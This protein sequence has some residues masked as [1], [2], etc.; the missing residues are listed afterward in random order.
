MLF[1]RELKHVCA[2]AVYVV[3]LGFLL[4]GWKTNF[5]GVT[6][7]EISAAAGEEL[8]AD[9]LA[10]GGAFLKKPEK[11]D[12]SY[13][14]RK[15]VVPEKIMCGGTDMLLLEYLKNSYA[16]YPF[17]YYKEV[18]LDDK[19]QEQVLEII[20]EI[21]GLEEEQLS[22]LPDGYFPQVNGNII[23]MGQDGAAFDGALKEDGSLSFSA[24]GHLQGQAGYR[25][26]SDE[27]LSFSAGGQEAVQF[28]AQVSY[29]RFLELMTKVE[30]LIGPGSN[31]SEEM[32]TEYYGQVE[33]TYEEALAAY[34]ETIREDQVSRA[35][36]R[37]F[38]DYM[39][40]M[41]GL[42]PAFVAVVFW[43]KDRRCHMQ[44]LVGSRQT[45]T[46]RLVITRYLALTTAA[47]APAML[48]SFESL[49]PL[50]RY[51]AETGIAIDVFAFAKY[52]LWWLAPTAMAVMALAMFLTILTRLS[53]AIPVALVWWLADSAASGLSGNIGVF[54]LMIRHNLLGGRQIIE[55][56]FTV[57]CLNRGLL[58]LV[59]CALVGLSVMAYERKRDG[60][61]NSDAKPAEI[62][63]KIY[64]WSQKRLGIH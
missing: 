39:G 55:E 9:S 33:M 64:S 34:E 42:Y 11:S 51:S 29:E 6:Q 3:F 47:L 10:A 46:A 45:A 20:K 50:M 56:N 54:T 61:T 32:L 38:C 62:K 58:I 19:E 12:E 28:E 15:K 63:R 2:S 25:S 1:A 53:L 41:L 13:G 49:L 40:R 24:G 36:A 59:S 4:F 14:A 60:R 22:N 48:L 26:C 57:I 16:S 17:G 43:R 44:E 31:Y 35:F 7:R 5:C 21:T 37:L 23:H 8:T 18:V 30:R 52:I 27:S